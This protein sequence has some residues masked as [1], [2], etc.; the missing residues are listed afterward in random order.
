MDQSATLPADFLVSL[1]ANLATD[2][3]KAG[4]RRLHAQAFGDAEQRALHDA[5]ASAFHR[6]LADVA[7]GL[8][9]ENR[10][11]VGHIFRAFVQVDG[12]AEALL[13]LALEG[14]EPPLA[15]LGERFDQLET[16]DRAALEVDFD[17]ALTALT[18]GLADAL[19]AEAM[20]PESPLH[21]RVSVVR[22]AAI[23]RL[24][25]NQ[26]RELAEIAAAVARLEQSLPAGA[27]YNLVF[28]GPASGFVVGDEARVEV[29]AD[30]RPLLEQTLALLTEIAAPRQP[31]PY[32]EADRLLYLEAVEDACKNIL[33]PYAR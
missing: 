33:L 25:R 20:Q 4:A 7:S 5:W 17:A 18:G 13:D 6:M 10:D 29:A 14:R 12:V 11:L 1:A 22:I 30:L 3:L 26:R 21:Q 15:L 8:E 24:L 23:H 31:P 2:L 16:L 28:L 19:L 9:L 32:T 27:R